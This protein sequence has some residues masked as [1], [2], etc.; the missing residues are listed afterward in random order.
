MA[1]EEIGGV[2]GGQEFTGNP[3]SRRMRDCYR[4]TREPVPEGL[5]LGGGL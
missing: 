4:C 2:G 3:P 1:Y 5:V